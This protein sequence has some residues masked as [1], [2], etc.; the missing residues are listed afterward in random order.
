MRNSNTRARCEKRTLKKCKGVCRTYSDIQSTM[1]DYLE[2]DENI[3]EYICNYALTD[4]SLK[5][6]NY[7]SDFFCKTVDGDMIVYECVFQKHLKRTLTYTLLDA[8]RTYWL[9]RGVKWRLVVDASK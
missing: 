7:T 3:K 5:D 4:F 8:S 2:S 6:G 1:A 9:K